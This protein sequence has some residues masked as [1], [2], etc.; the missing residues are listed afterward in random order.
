MSHYIGGEQYLIN[1]EEC[2]IAAMHRRL[3]E[4]AY[5]QYPKS[6]DSFIAE[7]LGI[8]ILDLYQIKGEP[9]LIG[10]FDLANAEAVIIKKAIWSYYDRSLEFIASKLLISDRTLY[11]KLKDYGLEDYKNQV[12]IEKTAITKEVEVIPQSKYF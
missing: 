4:Q 3:V 8:P 11:R 5:I 6:S 12:K 9:L 7:K 1:D 10:D 2:N